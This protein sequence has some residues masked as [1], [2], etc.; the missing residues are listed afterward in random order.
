MSGYFRGLPAGVN[1]PQEAAAHIAKLT[2][3]QQRYAYFDSI[4]IQW[5]AMVAH[6]AV[7]TIAAAIVEIESV[8]QR[9]IALA[10]VPRDWLVEL[11]SQVT[12]LWKLKKRETATA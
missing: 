2:T 9:R 1:S 11:K 4:P 10:R 3:R 12:R 8:E 6:E 7:L 5:Q